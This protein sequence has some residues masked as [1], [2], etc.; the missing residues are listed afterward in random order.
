MGF[1]DTFKGNHYKQEAEQLRM[2]LADVQKI[3]TPEMKEAADLQLF[4]RSLQER[5]SSLEQD[6]INASKELSVL[7]SKVDEK[8]KFLLVVDDEIAVQEF[9]LYKPNFEFANS[10]DYK[11]K[12]QEIRNKQKQLIK[13]KKAVIG[14]QNWQ[15][16]GSKSQGTKMVSD[17]QKLL[18]RAFNSECDEIIRNVKYTNYDK[19]LE[20]MQKSAETIS[21]LGTIMNISITY[22][23]RKSKIEEL[24]LAFEYRQKK[25]E[26]KELAAAA[27]AE[28]REAA[29]L[30]KEIDEQRK[31]YEKEQTHYQTAYK[32]ICEQL[33]NNPDD[34]D[35][36]AKKAEIEN[37]IADIE[38]SLED[39]DYRQANQKAGYVYIISNIG[40][41]GENIYKIGMTRRLDPQERID[42]LGDASVPFNFDVHAMIF[43]DNAPALESALHKAFEDRKVNMVNQRREFFNVTLDEI[44]KVV[45]NNFDKTVEFIDVPDAE[46]YRVSLKMREEQHT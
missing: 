33:N 39:I 30:Q 36:L 38:K 2:Q 22:E 7:Q 42:E 43:S 44:K 32:K 27:R 34:T 35:L 45:K 15:V 3:L 10:S 46:Q 5:H 17:M 8:K 37:H 4:I 20:R 24:R 21:K 41:F 11:D 18:L 40:A 31:K 26:E 16:N 1:L 28:M 12:L 14:N 25:Q 29:K 6:I 19:S 9:G 13:S 23:Y